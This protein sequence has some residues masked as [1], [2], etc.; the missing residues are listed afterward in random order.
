MTLPLILV[1]DDQYATDDFERKYFLNQAGLVERNDVQNNEPPPDA[2]GIA[3]FCSG[4]MEEKPEE[5][6]EGDAYIGN[7]IEV[8]ETAIKNCGADQLSLILMDVQFDSPLNDARE[9]KANPDDRFFNATLDSNFGFSL[10]E[11]LMEHVYN[12]P[13]IIMMSAHRQGQAARREHSIHVLPKNMLSQKQMIDILHDK[14]Q[15]NDWQRARL[16][17]VEL[18][19]HIR[20]IRIDDADATTGMLPVIDNACNELKAAM[21]GAA[22]TKERKNRASAARFIYGCDMGA[23]LGTRELGTRDFNKMAKGVESVLSVNAPDADTGQADNEIFNRRE[24][25]DRGIGTLLAKWEKWEDNGKWIR[26][27]ELWEN[28]RKN[29]R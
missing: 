12:C 29:R 24:L 15:I 20:T 25:T 28:R 17:L 23:R 6:T 16:D 22:L 7:D 27:R 26:W 5:P 1:V 10:K 14:G 3:V 18:V 11:Y 8:V 2:V 19:W 21:L 9:G 13:P 4:Q